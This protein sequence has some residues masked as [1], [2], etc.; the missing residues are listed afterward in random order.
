MDAL[1]LIKRAMKEKNT[2]QI[3]LAERLGYKTQSGISS[4]LQG[5]SIRMDTFVKMMSALGYSVMIKPFT[6]SDK[7]NPNVI[8]I[9]KEGE[10]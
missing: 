6:E 3:Q 2:T 9:N 5:K 8:T 4:R 7:V 1:E 10:E